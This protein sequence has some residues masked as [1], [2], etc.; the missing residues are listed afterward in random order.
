MKKLIRDVEVNLYIFYY[1]CTLAYANDID[2]IEISVFG[3]KE[4]F[5]E[6]EKNASN[7]GL[8][9]NEGKQSICMSTD[10][11]LRMRKIEIYKTILRPILSTE[12]KAGRGRNE[13]SEN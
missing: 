7:M 8:R 13:T 6:I 5:L 4:I 3:T 1:T 9:V 2:I 11:G 10:S 12:V